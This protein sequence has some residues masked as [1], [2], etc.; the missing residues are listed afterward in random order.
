MNVFQVAWKGIKRYF[1]RVV[2]TPSTIGFGVQSPQAYHFIRDVV[3]DKNRF[4]S[5][6]N[7]KLS[8]SRHSRNQHKTLLLYYR[9]A[10][11]SDYKNI[12]ICVEHPNVIIEYLHSL[13]CDLPFVKLKN[14]LGQMPIGFCVQSSFHDFEYCFDQMPNMPSQSSVA[15]VLN[16]CDMLI[17]DLSDY[18]QVVFNIFVHRASRGSILI[19]QDI[20]ST[21]Q[22]LKDWK[23]ICADNRTGVTFDLYDC[24]IVFFD[25]NMYKQHY[26][27]NL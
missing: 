8:G 11:S 12:C 3:R 16:D 21:P 13:L 19:V 23:K 26:K 6:E 22:S 20:Y 25:L 24:G 1:I 14:V 5:F 2:R 7:D 9:I 4:Y 18:W 10:K 15:A 27:V 17:M